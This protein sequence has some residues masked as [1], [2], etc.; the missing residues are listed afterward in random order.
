MYCDLNWYMKSGGLHG[1]NI[2][3]TKHKVFQIGSRPE[4]T[5]AQDCR[6]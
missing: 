4:I 3:L 1:A 2:N 5:I 6:D